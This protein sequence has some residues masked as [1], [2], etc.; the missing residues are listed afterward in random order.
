MAN[1]KQWRFSVNFSARGNGILE[2]LESSRRFFVLVE[3]AQLLLGS[4]IRVEHVLSSIPTHICDIFFKRPQST[5]HPNEIPDP[6][7]V[8]TSQKRTN[9]LTL[10][11]LE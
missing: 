1:Y 7:L 3:I 9:R 4:W 6:L 5:V 10:G 11:L 2:T 8:T